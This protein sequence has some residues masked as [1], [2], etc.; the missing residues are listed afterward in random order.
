MDSAI[1]RRNMVDS[2]VRPSDVTDRRIARAMLEVPR[3]TFVPQSKRSVA[4]MDGDIVVGGEGTHLPRALLAPRTLSKMIQSMALET[5]A[6]VLDVAPATGYSTAVLAH[7][8]RRVVAVECDAALAEDAK[9]A[10]ASLSLGNAD[11]HVGPLGEGFPAGGPYDA[12]L[13]GGKVTDVPASLLNQLKDGGR[14]VAIL[15]VNGVGKACEWCRFAMSFDHRVLFDAEAYV[16]P[17]FERVAE[18]VF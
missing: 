16:L 11:V 13:L 3:E 10:L 12:I 15:D 14:L 18:F 1:Q 2:Q 5:D 17:G 8:A 6:V 7:M 4:Y 9:S